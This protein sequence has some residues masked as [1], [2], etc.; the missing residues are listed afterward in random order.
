MKWIKVRVFFVGI[1]GIYE[2]MD[3]TKM[4]CIFQMFYGMRDSAGCHE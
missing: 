1:K 3:K 2:Y 4:L